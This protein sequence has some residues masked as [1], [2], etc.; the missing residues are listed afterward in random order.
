VKNISKFASNSAT[1]GYKRRSLTIIHRIL[2]MGAVLVVIAYSGSG[3]AAASP[4]DGRSSVE[5]APGICSPAIAL[6]S[7]S[8]KKDEKKNLEIGAHGCG[9]KVYV[10]KRFV[11]N[12]GFNTITIDSGA[13]LCFPDQNQKMDVSTILVNGLLQIGQKTHPI[14]TS[15]PMTLVTL[16]F[17]GKRPCAAGTNCSSFSKGVQVQAGGSLEIFGQKGVPPNGLNRTYLSLPAGPPEKYGKGTNVTEPVAPGAEYR[18]RVADDVTLGKGRW[19]DGD[20]LAVGSTSFSPYDTEIVKI[21]SIKSKPV[22]N[23][24][25]SDI[26]I[27]GTPLVHYH[28]GSKAPTPSQLCTVKNVPTYVACGTVT[29]C[30]SACTSQPSPLNYNDPVAQNYGVDERAP[31][32]LLTARGESGHAAELSVVVIG[33]GNQRTAA[34]SGRHA[35]IAAS[36]R[37]GA[38]RSSKSEAM[39]V[40]RRSCSPRGV[41]RPIRWRMT[42]PRLKPPA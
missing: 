2:A 21:G 40:A 20:W 17:V 5:I 41:P 24:T 34:M 29:G 19:Q 13:T 8:C 33:G 10:D 30:T 42:S 32:A 37:R 1:S 31:V 22:D 15:D 38:P 4:S 16:N 3:A 35:E 26:F 36:Q 25:G 27:L 14:G 28:F 12:D 6:S 9:P 18:L 23:P 39:T 11:D 7:G